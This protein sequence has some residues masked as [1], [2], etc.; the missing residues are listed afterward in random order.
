MKKRE[1]KLSIDVTVTGHR[2]DQI[3]TPLI[4]DA[5]QE[6]VNRRDF[7][8]GAIDQGRAIE[9]SVDYGNVRVTVDVSRMSID[10]A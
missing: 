1:F 8:V 10:P 5:M 2:E 3:I 4:N 9:H 6:L 7:R